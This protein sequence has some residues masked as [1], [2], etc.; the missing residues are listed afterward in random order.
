MKARVTVLSASMLLSAVLHAQAP[1]LAWAETI[2]NV[3]TPGDYPTVISASASNDGTVYVSGT[4]NG[5]LNIVGDTIVGQQYVARYDTAGTLLWARSPISGKV[6][7]A[8]ADG[9]YVSGAF[10]GSLQFG[11]NTVVAAATDAFVAKYDVNGQ[12]QWIRQMGGAGND[13]STDIAIDGLGRVH[14]SGWFQGTATFGGATLVATHDSTGYLTTLDASGNFLWSVRAGGLS[15]P[16]PLASMAIRIACDAAGVTY[17]AGVF[18]GTGSF[19]GSSLVAAQ[20]DDVFVARFDASGTCTWA[21]QMGG[22][23][24]YVSG[25][26][27]IPG[28][29]TYVTGGYASAAATFGSTTLPNAG[30]QDV[31][32]TRC[33]AGGVPIWATRLAVNAF[34]EMSFALSV[35]D[36]GNAWVF[37]YQPGDALFG[38]TLFP[39]SG[40]FLTQYD[41]AGNMLQLDRPSSAYTGLHSL[42]PEGE[43]YICGQHFVDWFDATDSTTV[44]NTPTYEGYVARYRPDLSFHWVQECGVHQ[45][46]YDGVADV[47][48]GDAGTSFI[49]GHSNTS[50]IFCNDT[51]VLG[52]GV[53]DLFVAGRDANGDCIWNRR[54]KT[55]QAPGTNT[56]A[57][58]VGIAR[59]TNGDLAVAGHFQGTLDFGGTIL[60]S[61]GG[62]DLFVARYDATGT[63]LWALS[64]GGPGMQQ[65]TGIAFDASGNVIVVGSFTDAFTI[66]TDALMTVGATDGFIAKFTSSGSPSWASTMGGAGFDGANNVGCD[67]TGNIHVIGSYVTQCTFGPI[68]VNGTGAQDLFVAKYSATGTPLWALGSTGAG[69]RQGF[70]VAVSPAGEIF[71]SGVHTGSTTFGSTSITGDPAINHALAGRIDASGTVQWLKQFPSS[72]E[73][74]GGA[75]A[76]RPSG[77]LVISGSYYFDVELDGT[78]LPD[79][80]GAYNI[81]L[82]GLLPSGSIDWTQSIVTTNPLDL[83]GGTVAADAQHVFVA[84]N[85][86]SA[87][88]D[89]F[90]PYIG[91]ATFMP[92]DP[93]S[94]RLA[95]NTFDGFLAKYE[96]PQS[97]G[98]IPEGASLDLV[99]SPNPVQ[100]LLTITSA[101]SIDVS[102]RM[103]VHDMTGRE[104]QVA[105]VRSGNTIHLDASELS[106]GVYAFRCTTAGRPYTLQFVKH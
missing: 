32:F 51:V 63:L 72:G 102:A 62:K 42:G 23:A 57:R 73:S 60:E 4:S 79:A 2:P 83:L 33:D 88:F 86:G 74:T 47:V 13:A 56:E 30:N 43:H 46:A 103:N 84:G 26:G 105:M 78:I 3:T 10:T 94:E 101:L 54:I 53:T 100:D 12:P 52:L 80:G 19:G 71:F 38:T 75:L 99:A 6:A 85:F 64:E 8:G 96:I 40:M 35:D 25:I 92:G 7:A 81:F 59:A 69:S 44:G 29:G 27:L 15:D 106:P 93:S 91:S 66:G 28:G 65:A 97:V 95:P 61:T 50:A 104:V 21:Q 70:D 5:P 20:F 17:A 37:G 22:N 98:I 31:F 82:S 24:N 68:T 1:T 34:S 14:V 16:L 58:M 41:T 39:G 18:D 49:C 11:G 55:T 9:V 45:A 87:V 90:T 76:L 48:V 36:D 67:V 89:G 77:E